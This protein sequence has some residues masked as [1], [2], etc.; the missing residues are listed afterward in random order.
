MHL[1]LHI[2]VTAVFFVVGYQ[3]ERNLTGW[4]HTMLLGEPNSREPE[5]LPHQQDTTVNSC[6][7]LQHPGPA[8]VL[9]VAGPAVLGFQG[10]AK[11]GG[12]RLNRS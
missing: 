3:G 7:T 12:R 5:A 10:N 1:C 6:S 11:V 8:Q 2:V 9:L 4:P